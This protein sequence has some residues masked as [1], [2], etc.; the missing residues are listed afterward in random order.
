LRTWR[1]SS[2]RTSTSM[3]K[4]EAKRAIAHVGVCVGVCACVTKRAT[5]RV[6]LYVCVL[7]WRMEDGNDD[8]DDGGGGCVI[9]SVLSESSPK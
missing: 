1:I 5:T 8:W 9:L 2:W 4:P 7:F 6:C 3:R